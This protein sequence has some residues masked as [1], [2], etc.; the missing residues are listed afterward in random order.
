M[1]KIFICANLQINA[2]AQT[3]SAAYP[4]QSAAAPGEHDPS[5][6]PVHANAKLTQPADFM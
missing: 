1:V 4:A 2:T 5:T 6:L 3:D